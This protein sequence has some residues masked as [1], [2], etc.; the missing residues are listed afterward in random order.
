[1]LGRSKPARISPSSGMPSWTRMSARVRLSAVAVSA[2]RGTSRCWSS[3]RQQQPIV[4]PEIMA[5][6]A[7]A[8]R[9]VDREQRDVGFLQQP[10]ETLGRR[11][12]GRDIEQVELGHRAARRRIAARIVAGAG[13][14]QRRESRSR[15]RCAPGPASARSAGK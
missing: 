15:R 11:P 13:Q 9:L 10:R 3:K 2:S 1:M 4:G 14:R 8:M 5:P 6:F 12:L 7:D